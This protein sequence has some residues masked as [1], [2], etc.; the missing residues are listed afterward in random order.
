M[1]QDK[2]YDHLVIEDEKRG[3]RTNVVEQEVKNLAH[4][5]NDE[6]LD[7]IVCSA[8][9]L[10]A[11]RDSLPRNFMYVTPGIKGPRTP[12]GDDQNRVFTPGNAIQDG[13]SILVV[14]RAITD[15]RTKEQKE[16]KVEVTEE[17]IQQAGYEVLQ[18]MAPHL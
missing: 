13:S 17:M 12:A 16:Q 9:D 1:L 4:I 2:G 11:V 15:P 14:G 7:G 18:D 3:L 5:A 8:A 6:G 10:Y